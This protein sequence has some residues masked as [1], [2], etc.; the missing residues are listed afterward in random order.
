MI[1]EQHVLALPAG[2]QLGKYLFKGVL[3]SGGFGITY[4]AEDITL[5]RKVAVKEM[6]PNDFATPIDGTTV[7]AKNESEEA[8]LA[9]ARARFVDG[10]RAIAARD[11]PKVVHVFHMVL[12][13]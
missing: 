1:A 5:N 3:G 8:K 7:V 10:R 2:Y 4:L 13:E 12:A 9:W 6:L 11:H